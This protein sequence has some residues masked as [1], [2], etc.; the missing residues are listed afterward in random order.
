MYISMK[1][2]LQC[3]HSVLYL[4]S[5]HC[6]VYKTHSATNLCILHANAHWEMF[7]R[8]AEEISP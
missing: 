1:N 3:I 6:S 2:E 5:I 4:C 8:F 7:F